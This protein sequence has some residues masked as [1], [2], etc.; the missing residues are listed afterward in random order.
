MVVLVVERR[1][2]DWDEQDNSIPL[3]ITRFLY[4]YSYSQASV[5]LEL[6]TE[7]SSPHVCMCALEEIEHPWE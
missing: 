5:W 3:S 7:A 6:G 1:E 4:S 2:E